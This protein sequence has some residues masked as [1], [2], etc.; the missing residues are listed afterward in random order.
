MNQSSTRRLTEG[1]VLIAFFAV[2]LLIS[3]YVP[4]L[5]IVLNVFLV[6]PF[7]IYSSKYSFRASLVM[8]AAAIGVSS[9]LG[10]I[11][12]IPLAFAYSTTGLVMG[13]MIKEHKS[14]F[15]IFISSTLV[16]LFHVISQYV[17]SILFFEINIVD[18][19]FTEM[20]RAMIKWFELADSNNVDVSGMKETWSAN[21]ATMEMLIPTLLVFSVSVIV[22]IMLIANFPIAKRFN[23]EV[24][25]FKP[26]REL[27]L[28]K[29]VIWYYL[30]VLITSLVSSPEP[31]TTFALAVINLQIGL[32]LLMILQGL[33]FI[34]FWGHRKG[35]G[36][37]R[38]AILTIF[39]IVLSPFTRILGIIDLG[40]D[41]RERLSQ[42]R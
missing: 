21:M 1:A 37:G 3:I 33:A 15:M 13:W 26:F 17:V 11:L 16:F 29:S 31:G 23:I 14:K 32:E 7:I 20:D 34:H 4:P 24:P 9:I 5:S 22:W 6:L 36:K 25:R 2:L 39:G 42:K 27:S 10:S 18:E 30:I 38:I 12:A 41:L 8:V 28:P 19:L 35:W 40:F